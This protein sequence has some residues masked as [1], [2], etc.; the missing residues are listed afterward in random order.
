MTKSAKKRAKSAEVAKARPMTHS[1]ELKIQR[2]ADEAL[3]QNLAYLQDM[4]KRHPTLYKNE[5]VKHFAVFKAKM[6]TFKESP[7]KNDVQ[8]N[9]YMLFLSHVSYIHLTYLSLDIS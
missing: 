8:F 6:V 2:N 9:S 5:F 3:K 4:I 1:E 7:A